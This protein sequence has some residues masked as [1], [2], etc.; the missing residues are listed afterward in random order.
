MTLKL[1]GRV[2][3]QGEIEAK[4]GLHI[5]GSGGRSRLAGWT[6]RSSLIN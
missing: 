5:G 1:Y 3:I 4:T 6:T 2:F